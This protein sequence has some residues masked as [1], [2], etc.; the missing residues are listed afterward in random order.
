MI[1]VVAL[2]MGWHILV[3][4]SAKIGVCGLFRSKPAAPG[5]AWIDTGEAESRF[6]WQNTGVRWQAGLEHPEFKAE[7][8][9]NEGDWVPLPGYAL[10]DKLQGLN[11]IWKVGLKHPDFM[12]WSDDVEGQWIPVTGYRFVYEGDT[13]VD[14]VWDPNKRYDDVKVMS[15]TEK[16]HYQPFPGYTFT[17]PGQSLKVIWT[18]G[19]LNADNSRLIAGTKEGTWNINSGSNSN[20]SRSSR[21]G[22]EAA[23][24]VGGVATGILLR[25]L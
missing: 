11:T 21:R 9:E 15:L 4:M 10:I 1:G 3:A 17:E 24:F 8:T 2:V 7:T 20:R 22:N 19:I 5:Y 14:T 6:F 13:F 23:W 25:S 18:P 16:D 12:A